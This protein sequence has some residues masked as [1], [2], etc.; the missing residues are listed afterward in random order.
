MNFR[1][2]RLGP[3]VFATAI[4]FAC[5]AVVLG[6][7]APRPAKAAPEVTIDAPPESFFELVAQR[8][9]EVARRFY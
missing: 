9:R 3:F 8:D 7:S 5:P 2:R 6:Q 4:A 1:L